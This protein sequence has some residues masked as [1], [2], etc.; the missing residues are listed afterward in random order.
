LSR[1]DPGL[2]TVAAE[3]GKPKS[4]LI[5]P[6]SPFG[7]G[8][9]SVTAMFLGYTAILTPPMI[10]FHWCAPGS[11]AEAG[12]GGG[13]WGVSDSCLGADDAPNVSM[14][15]R[16]CSHSAAGSP[17][18]FQ[19]NVSMPACALRWLSYLRQPFRSAPTGTATLPLIGTQAPHRRCLIKFLPSL[20]PTQAGRRVC[21]R[22]DASLRHNPR[23]I[24][25]NGN[26]I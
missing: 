19:H 13:G 14:P 18:P 4:R 26:H 23:H 8:W 6:L 24:F 20:P 11:R 3:S 7:I 15:A 2:R 21:R 10:S 9:I 25:L 1:N 5:Y 17:T 16:A 22:S 12:G